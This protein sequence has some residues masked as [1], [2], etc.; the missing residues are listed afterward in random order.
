MASTIS[1]L[2]ILGSSISTCACGSCCILPDVI[3]ALQPIWLVELAE[4]WQAPFA[5]SKRCQFATEVSESYIGGAEKE[6]YLV[7]SFTLKLAQYNICTA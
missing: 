4:E 6:A 7:C 2:P 3:L 1:S 5:L